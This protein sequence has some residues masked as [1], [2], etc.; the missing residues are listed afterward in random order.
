KFAYVKLKPAAKNM[1]FI[2][3]GKDGVKDTDADRS[4]DPSKNAEVWLKQGDPA[5]DPNTA[6]IH[7]HRADGDYSGWG[8]H[9]WDGAATGTDW[10]SPLQP[11]ATD[12]YGVTFTVPLAA[13]A[14]GLSYIIHKGD[15][16][17]LP[18][19]QRLDFAAAG[20]EVWLFAGVTDR[21]LPVV[22]KAGN[23]GVID[24]TKE[25]AVWIDRGTI[26]WKPGDATDGKKYALAYA[27][28]GGIGV[29]DGELTGS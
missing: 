21:L 13:G 9:V 23:A 11:A 25:S 16:K 24:L 8:L 5:E 26:A 10:G 1:G 15:T 27:N 7:Y 14:T 2:V 6:I 17:D 3:V 29:A 12:S 18:D 19:D 4:L 20:R 28:D 22:K